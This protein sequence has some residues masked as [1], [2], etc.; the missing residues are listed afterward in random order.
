M[1]EKV[2][3]P[4]GSKIIRELAE[5]QKK[6]AIIFDDLPGCSHRRY[7]SGPDRYCQQGLHCSV[8]LRLRKFM[9]KQFLQRISEEYYENYKD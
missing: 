9:Q 4:V 1:K 3:S 6:A 2:A 8:L 7:Y 5:G